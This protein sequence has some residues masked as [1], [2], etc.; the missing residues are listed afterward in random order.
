MKTG[1]WHRPNDTGAETDLNGIISVIEAFKAAGIDTVFVE[2]FYHGCTAYRSELVPYRAELEAFTYGAYPDYLTAFAA[3]AA[4]RGITTH[5]WVED[6][7]VGAEENFFTRERPGWL[8]KTRSGAVRQSE[9][10]GYIFLDPA[11]DGA[12]DYLIR[13]YRELLAK[14]P[15]VAGLNLDY[16]RYPLSS[17]EDDTGYTAA[18]LEKFAS[19]PEKNYGEW[20]AFRAGLI[21]EFVKKVRQAADGALVSTAVFPE[22]ELSYQSKKQD[23]TRW[24]KEG[25]LD[26]VTPMVYYDGLPE[27]G[28]AL[29]QTMDYCRGTPCFAGLSCTYHGLGTDLM[30]AQI[31]ESVRL[32]AEGVVFFSSKSLL[33]NGAYIKALGGRCAKELK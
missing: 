29:K 23:F 32:G 30:L 14:Q 8:L 19:D 25:L 2:S 10:G 31:D 24:L 15:H 5:A 27:F 3:E 18:A 6:F 13:I 21:T 33:K 12:A 28:A 1:V 7:Y 22:V 4:A 17:R 20:V 9:G 11:N 16:I 26:F